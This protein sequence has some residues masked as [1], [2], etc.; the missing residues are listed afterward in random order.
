ME[1][2]QQSEVALGDKLMN[3]WRLSLFCHPHITQLL[4]VFLARDHIGMVMAR[5]PSGRDL[6][7]TFDEEIVSGTNEHL[8][9]G[10]ARRI[11]QQL[12]FAVDFAHLLGENLCCAAATGASPLIYKLSYLQEG[13]YSCIQYAAVANEINVARQLDAGEPSISVCSSSVDSRLH[14]TVHNVTT[15]KS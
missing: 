1:V 13:Y 2:Y 12:I 9:I 6:A 3:L 7:H 10:E 11:F 15:K 4:E 8:P 14:I 5:V